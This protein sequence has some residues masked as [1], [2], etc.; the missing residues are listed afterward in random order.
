MDYKEKKWKGKIQFARSSRDGICEHLSELTKYQN[1]NYHD[2]WLGVEKER[3]YSNICLKNKGDRSWLRL[4]Q[5]K[6]YKY[7][8]GNDN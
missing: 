1:P 3:E 2:T 4:Q 7:L 5:Y 8:L 6:K